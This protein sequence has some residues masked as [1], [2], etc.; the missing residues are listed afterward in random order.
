MVRA[1]FVVRLSVG[2]INQGGFCCEVICGKQRFFAKPAPTIRQT[3][4]VSRLR[5]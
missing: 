5:T 2:N 3:I 4:Q 1:G